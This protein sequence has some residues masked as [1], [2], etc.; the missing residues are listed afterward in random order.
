MFLTIADYLV[1]NIL[2]LS[3]QTSFGA[4][5]HFFVYDVL[6][7]LF[8]LSIIIFSIS[9]LQTY[10]NTQK[11]KTYIEKQPKFL[12]HFLAAL[13]GAVTPFCSCSSIPVFIGFIEAKIPFGI[14]MSFLITSPMINEIAM[15]V[16]A[17]ILG[18]KIT[19]IYIATGIS[20]GMLGGY[21]LEK[22]GYA[23]YLQD[24][25]RLNT[26]QFAP[27]ACSCSVPA[28]PQIL[29]SAR[30][31]TAAQKT[32]TLLHK[33]WLF[34]L[35]GIGAGAFLH[36]YVP[37]EFFLRYMQA[38]NIFAVPLAVLAGIP[39]YADATTMIPIAEVLIAKGSAIGT[40]LAFMM[41]VV[42]LSLPEMI[43]LAKVMKR[44]LIVRYLIFMAICFI[45]IGYFYNIIL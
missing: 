11:I 40:V 37:Q 13:F 33:I 42:G 26:L 9:F 8:L 3:P 44:Q 38:D 20:I 31:Q 19:L 14:A 22:L 39:L 25:L 17:G 6:K 24:Y 27:R 21:L 32:R 35:L 45:L 4:A 16:L 43:I 12:A 15:L 10:M 5:L 29:F 2:H 28:A 41:A 30:I 34:I 7:I 1:Y 18:I 36:G 23:Q